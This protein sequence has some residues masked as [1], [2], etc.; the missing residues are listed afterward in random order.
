MKQLIIMR[1]AQADSES[2]ARDFDRPLTAEG[3]QEAWRQA[4]WL[5]DKGIKPDVVLS[6]PAAR[7]RDTAI[8]A[9]EHLGID[10]RRGQLIRSVYE[11]SAGELIRLVEEAQPADCILLVGHNPGVSSLAGL[12][13]GS[14]VTLRPASM[15]RLE[16]DPAVNGT[17]QPSSARLAELHH[18]GRH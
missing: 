3:R 9:C 2:A 16:F 12:L 5:R 18:T 4:D 1:H 15:A 17:P 8:T 10:P 6:S 13:V 7:A 14:Y 11:A